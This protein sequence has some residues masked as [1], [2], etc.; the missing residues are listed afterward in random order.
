MIPTDKIKKMYE[1]MVTI[2]EADVVFNQAQR[3]SRISFY[4]TQT[5]EEASNIGTAAA[6]E[7]HDLLFPQYRESGAFLWR[8]FSI[9]QMAHQLCGNYKDFG[10]G[11]QMP[12]HY[13]SKDL[14]I[15]TVSSPL[16][17]QLPQAS[18]AGYKYRINNENRIAV[19]YFG[20]GAA[21]EGDF[22][23]A[24]NF[25]ATLRCQTLFYCRNNMYAISTPIDDQYA[26]DG[27][28]VRG[29]SYGM[30]TLRVDG[31]DIFAIYA[32]TKQAREM[33]I[34]DKRPVLIEAMSYRIG[35]HS[36]SDNSSA[37]RTE[38]EMEKWKDLMQKVSNPITRLEKYLLREGLITADQNE[39][40]RKDA[41]D[42]VRESLKAASDLPKPS[43]DWMF[44][45]VYDGLPKHI[46]EQ[47]EQ[48]RAHLRK[49]PDQYHLEKFI[50]GKKWIY[51][52]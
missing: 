52:I 9:Q 32:A 13:G 36:T 26:G 22:H 15:C 41:R 7:D 43:I 40:L 1:T 28:A 6:I 46:S 17:T 10:Q 27:I 5:G 51:L 16:C 21:S 18:G 47:K 11:K 14:N 4:M 19:T 2:N 35:D 37:Y 45:S 12:V 49:Y 23:P 20:E 31:N 38:K 24:L 42:A 25:A 34:R 44:D 8:G 3:Q 48:L 33:I 39:K 29:V 30:P 50:D